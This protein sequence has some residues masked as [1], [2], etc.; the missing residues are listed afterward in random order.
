MEDPWLNAW[1]DDQNSSPPQTWSSSN[2]VTDDQVDI[3]VPSWAPESPILWTSDKSPDADIL[4][5]PTGQEPAVIQE[6]AC[7]P[8]D[9]DTVCDKELSKES[10]AD[11]DGPAT[12]DALETHAPDPW[13]LPQVE[14]GNWVDTDDVVRNNNS[15]SLDEWELAKRQ[16]EL[17]D[18]YVVR[19]LY[20]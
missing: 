10:L 9:V 18:R 3:A 20:P 2:N 1:R 4:P 5:P 17:Q 11:T 16:K 14:G 7:T 12:E 13:T 19:R 6:D 15:E 8:T